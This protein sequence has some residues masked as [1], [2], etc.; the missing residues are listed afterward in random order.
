MSEHGPSVPDLPSAPDLRADGAFSGGGVKALAFAGA[1]KAAEEAGYRDWHRLAGTSAGA[2]TAMSL[3][4]GHTADS[5]AELLFEFDFKTIVDKGDPPRLAQISNL[6]S[7]RALARGEALREW[8]R[9]LLSRAPNQVR[10]FGDLEGRLTVVATDLV[11]KRMVVFPDD[12]SLYCDPNGRPW[13]PKAFPIVD[14]VRISAGYPFM[15]PPVE[16]RDAAT[17][18]AAALVDGGIVSSFPVFVFDHEQGCHPTWAFRLHDEQITRPH[19]PL[20]GLR[21]PLEM[22][23][24]VL[25]TSMNALD[26]LEAKTFAERTI[27][28]PTG[29]IPTLQFDL[30]DADKRELWHAGY[31]AAKAFFVSAPKPRNIYGVSPPLE[32]LPRSTRAAAA[33]AATI[34]GS[35]ER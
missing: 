24:A 8:I 35:S 3:A 26:S 23:R 1:L 2:I 25:D 19:A 30:S 27:A 17:G 14:A 6:V 34:T 20:R 32:T 16:L 29:T 7:R 9:L 15:F 4:A 33:R 31:D 13:D 18:Q 11:H 10:T 28:I 22:M 21:W 5:L 12:A